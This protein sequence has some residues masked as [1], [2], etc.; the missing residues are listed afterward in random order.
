MEKENAELRA[1]LNEN[2]ER[3]AAVEHEGSN[4]SLA[5]ENQSLKIGLASV[6]EVVEE[7]KV[8]AR[9][10][11]LLCVCALVQALAVC[12]CLRSV[13][14]MCVRVC[15]W[16]CASRRQGKIL[17]LE[18]QLSDRERQTRQLLTELR[19]AEQ[20]SARLE[21][22]L[23][24]VGTVDLLMREKLTLSLDIVCVILT[25]QASARSSELASS[26]ALQA[27]ISDEQHNEQEQAAREAINGLEAKLAE[28]EQARLKLA[29]VLLKV[30]QRG[31][32]DAEGQALIADGDAKETLDESQAA[33]Q[34]RDATAEGIAMPHGAQSIPL[35]ASTGTAAR[36]A[37]AG[38]SVGL[39]ED[40][41]DAES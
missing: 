36:D 17:D 26:Q 31:R 34:G 9:C 30:L 35:Q 29:A 12:R 14:I 10:V 8:V 28:S 25:C 24:K 21:A 33:Q 23:S 15:V 6:T 4:E 38:E 40:G 7:A 41:G 1:R 19:D 27:S 37:A 22:E 5:L 20:A 13:I 16:M 2:E 3:A 32:Q 39:S 18:S 11:H